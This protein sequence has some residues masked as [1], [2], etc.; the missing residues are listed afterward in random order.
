[1]NDLRLAD[2]TPRSQARVTETSVDRA[3]VPCIDVHNHLGR[4][5]SHDGGWILQDVGELLATMDAC[6][7]E[8]VVNLDGRWGEDLRANLARY[9]EAHPG[10]FLTF[11]HLDWSRLAEPGGFDRLPADLE[12]A[13][14][15]GA[16]GVKV[17]KDLGLTHRDA[18]GE[19]VLP[20]DPRLDAAFAAAGE[21]GLPIL[22]HTADPIAF[23]DPLDA[24]NERLEELAGQP[25][26]WFGGEGHPT[27]DRLLDALDARL[28]RSSRTSFIG[29][30]VGC[31]AEDLARVDRMLTAHPNFHVDV[32][33]RMAEIGRQPRAFRRLVEAH[34]DR[35]LFGTDA[36]P[37]QPE[38]YRLWFRFLETDDE[39]FAYS[40]GDPIPPQGR[41]AVS[42]LDLS[43][44]LL[45]GIYRDNA[46]RVLGLDLG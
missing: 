43:G 16:K 18:A 19:L 20:D 35:V 22:I 38:D 29:A 21:L 3:A 28:G 10:R 25:D 9:D 45:R 41:W 44:D 30:H 31:V 15:A 42:A 2:Y 27:F 33:G 13:A 37:V 8:T 14:A 11:C 6:G 34:P 26:W 5:L 32:G 36:F 1:M 40:P 7:V 17:W 4:W 46:A 39:C 24:H 12:A 23:F